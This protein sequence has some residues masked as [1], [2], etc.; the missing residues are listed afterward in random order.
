MESLCSPTNKPVDQVTAGVESGASTMTA[1]QT[2]RILQKAERQLKKLKEEKARREE[3]KKA[4]SERTKVGAW[5]RNTGGPG[6]QALR[7]QEA[8]RC[9]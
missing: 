8:V 5:G 6:F 9:D 4:W 2:A 1:R 7:C 3:L